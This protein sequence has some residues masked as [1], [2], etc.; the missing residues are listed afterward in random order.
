MEPE[1]VDDFELMKKKLQNRGKRN[2][3]QSE[4]V[5]SDN[6]ASSI[7]EQVLKAKQNFEQANKELGKVGVLAKKL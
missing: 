3:I 1:M 7:D 4:F 6:E 5:D 2:L